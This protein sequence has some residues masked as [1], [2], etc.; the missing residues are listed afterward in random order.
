MNKKGILHYLNKINSNEK[1]KYFSIQANR[2]DPNSDSQPV[3]VILN[4]DN[5]F[6]HLGGSR[7]AI[8]T[9]NVSIESGYGLYITHFLMKSGSGNQPK[10]WKVEAI[11]NG[12]LIE[13]DNHTNSTVFS[14]NFTPHIFPVKQGYFSSF[15]ISLTDVN[16]NGFLTFCLSYIDFYGILSDSDGN[17]IVIATYYKYCW[18]TL[19]TKSPILSSYIFICLSMLHM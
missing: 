3:D 6:W 16:M 7:S 10:S 13:I 12:N 4:D 14:E 11:D 9:V 2:I 18:L 8:P 19:N 1:F 15:I 5:Q 17:P